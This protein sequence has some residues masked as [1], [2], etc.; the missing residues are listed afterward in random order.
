LTPPN[1]T[2]GQPHA[3][4]IT[5]NVDAAYGL[6]KKE[7]TCSPLCGGDRV[8]D[9]FDQ[10]NDKCNRIFFAWIDGLGHSGG[11]RIDNCDAPPSN[12]NGG[13]SIVGNAKA[14]FAEQSIVNPG[15]SR[16]SMPF[17]YDNRYGDSY[18]T[19]DIPGEDWTTISVK[20]LSLSFRGTTGNTGTLY[21]MI[22][23]TKIVYDGN[24]ADIAHGA[25]Q[26][27]S[28]DLTDVR[29]LQNV[30]SLSIGVDGAG[31]AGMLYIDDI[32]LPP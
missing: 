7:F 9:D 16:Q 11:K 15:G 28:I 3:L 27:W 32:R 18:A 14:P 23:N 2:D 22:N 26:V 4:E 25:W 30:T 12:G 1:S 5:V 10:Y 20:S 24:P 13:G 31:A 19:L 21:V 8:V 29:G 6:D 17:N